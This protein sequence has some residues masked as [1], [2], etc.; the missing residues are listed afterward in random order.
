MLKA[1]ADEFQMTLEADHTYCVHVCCG[2]QMS[3]YPTTGVCGSSRLWWL[4]CPEGI[5]IHYHR[6][7]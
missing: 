3:H 7:I 1:A 6:F 4:C 2:G 5:T